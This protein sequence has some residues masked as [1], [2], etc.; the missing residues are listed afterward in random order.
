MFKR[1][2]ALYRQNGERPLRVAVIGSGPSGFYSAARLLS[3]ADDKQLS[4]V[5]VHM[6]ERLPVPNGLVRYGVAPDHLDVKNVENRFNEIAGDK[7]FRFFGNVNVTAGNDGSTQNGDLS[8]GYLYPRAISLPLNDLAKHYTHILFAYGCSESRL[9][10]IPGSSPGELQNVHSALD[11]VNWYNGHPIA[12]DPEVLEKE[13]WR[14]V[15]LSSLQQMSIIGAGN[16]ALDV[17]RIVLR[18]SQNSTVAVR[19]ELAKGDIPESVLKHLDDSPIKS[20]D[21]NARRGPAQVAFTN[22]EL[23]EMMALPGIAFSTI[24]SDLIKDAEKRVGEEEV[25]F[26]SAA[27][28]GTLDPDVA[29]EEAG[30][31]RIRKRLLSLLAKGSATKGHNAEKQWSLNFFR[32]PIAFEGRDRIESVKWTTTSLGQSGEAVTSTGPITPSSTWG[33]EVPSKKALDSAPSRQNNP[34]DSSDTFSTS[35][36][37]LV[38]SVGYKGSPLD[39]SLTAPNGDG[40]GGGLLL[41][42]DA[43]KGVVP[44]KFGRVVDRSGKQIPRLYVAGWLAKGPVGVIASTMYDAYSVADTLIQDHFSSESPVSQLAHEHLHTPLPDLPSQL[45]APTK[46]LVQWKDWQRID[47]V[48]RERGQ[49]L[50]KVREKILSI[51]EMINVVS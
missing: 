23:R 8:R 3:N 43:V 13:P 32:A 19:E 18:S 50:G 7:R 38:S 37:V 16:V 4:D 22:K 48:E 40:G 10:G 39:G 28:D 42:W 31:F 36:D 14:R 15:N 25:N 1:S 21:I 17:A 6:Y 44:N 30:K 47:Q 11:F 46:K 20:V 33:N 34:Q 41:P 24:Q 27:K 9:L 12:H 49:Q 5:S 29:A 26:K 45:V 51:Q 2:I 35:T